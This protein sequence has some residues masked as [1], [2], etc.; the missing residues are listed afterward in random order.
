MYFQVPLIRSLLVLSIIH[1]PVDFTNECYNL[2][3]RHSENLFRTY[4]GF[5][6][7]VCLLKHVKIKF[8]LRQ[9]GSHIK[10]VLSV[11]NI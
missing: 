9:P 7:V 1:V 2:M 11:T 5:A 4:K 3:Q 10:P 8:S 6:R